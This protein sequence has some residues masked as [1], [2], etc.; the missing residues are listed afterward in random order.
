M[1]DGMFGVCPKVCGA[2]PLVRRGDGDDDGVIDDDFE[3]WCGGRA[4]L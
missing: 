3:K 1:A 2:K 4:T